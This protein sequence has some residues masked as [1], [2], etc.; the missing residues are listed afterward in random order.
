MS[1]Y[2]PAFA[3]LFVACACRHSRSLTFD[4][5]KRFQPFQAVVEGAEV[6]TGRCWGRSG[7]LAVEIRLR[8]QDGALVAINADRATLTELAL[9]LDLTKGAAYEWPKAIT[10]FEAVVHAKCRQKL[11]STLDPEPTESTGN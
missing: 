1:K 5:A 10:D 3:I 11:H 4:E 9:A 2:I 6:H 8:R 7:G